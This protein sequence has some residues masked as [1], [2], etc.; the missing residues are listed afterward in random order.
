MDQPRW[1]ERTFAARTAPEL[2][3]NVRARLCGI[4]A[5]V[6]HAAAG[7]DHETLTSRPD[8]TRVDPEERRTPA[9]PRG[10]VGGA[11]RELLVRVP[12]L[13]AWDVTNQK[14]ERADHPRELPAILADL[15]RARASWLAPLLPRDRRVRAVEAGTRGSGRSCG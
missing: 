3:P 9:R 1:L 10:A 4:A 2:H 13:S 11:C 15:E 8:G 12:V 14:T 6:A 5:R 7:L